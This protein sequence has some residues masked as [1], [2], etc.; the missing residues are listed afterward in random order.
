MGGEDADTSLVAKCSGAWNLA[1][2]LQVLSD[3]LLSTS[4]EILRAADAIVLSL[5]DLYCKI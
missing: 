5:K 2:Q 1:Q 4:F 3:L